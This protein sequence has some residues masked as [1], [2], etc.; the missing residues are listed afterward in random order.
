[1]FV[2]HD[3]RRIENMLHYAT[4][5]YN[6]TRSKVIT[7]YNVGSCKQFQYDEKEEVFKAIL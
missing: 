7:C 4:Q 3:I 2:S 5:E 6:N 1:M